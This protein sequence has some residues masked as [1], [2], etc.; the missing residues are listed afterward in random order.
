MPPASP[1]CDAS[2]NATSGPRGPFGRFF[3]AYPVQS[4]H[5]LLIPGFQTGYSCA[6]IMIGRI[7]AF[8]VKLAPN[9]PGFRMASTVRP[10]PGNGRATSVERLA[11]PFCRQTR[12]WL[13]I[14][15]KL[16]VFRMRL[17][18]ASFAGSINEPID[19]TLKLLGGRS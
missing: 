2:P 16:Y 7:R 14:R 6:G 12:E 4:V 5:A 13:Q 19:V 18:S 15:A 1:G 3:R 8:F 9:N 11:A 17:K 10:F